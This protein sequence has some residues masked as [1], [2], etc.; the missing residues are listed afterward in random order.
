MLKKKS[1]YN[2]LFCS[3]HREKSKKKIF[4]CSTCIKIKD[5]L[6]ENGVKNTLE[7]LENNYKE[8]IFPALASAPCYS[9]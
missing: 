2:C 1:K 4:F 5:Y 7:K 6:R 3:N 9:K 8:T